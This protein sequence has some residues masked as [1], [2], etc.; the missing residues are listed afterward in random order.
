MLD[1]EEPSHARDQ[2]ET[3]KYEPSKVVAVGLRKATMT[4]ERAYPV[5]LWRHGQSACR[6]SLRLR[7]S[8][9]LRHVVSK[10]AR[11]AAAC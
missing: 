2:R 3:G 8:I 11:G 7:G 10:Q 9:S 4:G 6:S 1:S 5:S